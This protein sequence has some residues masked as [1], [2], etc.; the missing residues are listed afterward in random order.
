LWA[1]GFQQAREVG[2]FAH[3]EVLESKRGSLKVVEAKHI[4]PGSW[5]RL[6]FSGKWISVRSMKHM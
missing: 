6:G 4:V 1:V 2:V 5:M 3:Y